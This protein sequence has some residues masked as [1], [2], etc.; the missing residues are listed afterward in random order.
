[1][2]FGQATA[3]PPAFGAAPMFG[4][5][6]TSAAPAFGA[7]S[8][9]PAF[10]A[11]T[12]TFGAAAPAFAATGFGV[13]ST[14]AP[15]TGFGGFG[16]TTTTSAP[17]I[18]FGSTFGASAAPAFGTGSTFGGGVGAFGQAAPTQSLFG[19]GFGQQQ[20]AATSFN[21]NTPA[22]GA[23]PATSVGFGSTF[24]QPQQQPAPVSILH[25][26]KKNC[27]QIL[28][29]QGGVDR[30]VDTIP[31]ILDKFLKIPKKFLKFI[32]IPFFFKIVKFPNI[33]KSLRKNPVNLLNLNQK[34]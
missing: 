26:A 34:L 5:S 31:L 8:A 15:N 17:S 3:N 1:M 29:I 18:G 6:M 13:G 10:G 24:G 9:A 30:G 27:S 14:A 16:T 11:T 28:T 25:K 4:G 32:E 2:T 21:F 22:F 33:K 20:P 12:S 23:K 19:A 7:S